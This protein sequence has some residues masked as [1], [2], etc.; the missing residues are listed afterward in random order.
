MLEQLS[1]PSMK[2]WQW[3]FFAAVFAAAFLLRV[4]DLSRIF[5]W[6]DETDLFNESIYG[7]HH[8]SLLDFAFG[9]RNGTTQSWGWSAIFWIVT[10]AFGP[11]I[12]VARMPAVLV[13][14]AGVALLFALVYRLLPESSVNRFWP[15]L[16]AAIFAAISVVQMNYSQQTYPYGATPFLALAVMLARFEVRAAAGVE[17]KATPRL[18]RAVT[19]YTAAISLSFCVHASA[20]LIPALSMAVIGFGALQ[21]LRSQT[22]QERKRLLRW[23]AASGVIIVCA[24]ALGAKNPKYGYRPYLADYYEAPSLHAIPNL[25][26]HAYGLG[27]YAL[28]LFY[29]P[30]LY[31]PNRLNPAILPL[32]LICIL[33]WGL[34]L[35]GQ[36]GREIRHLAVFSAAA[37]ALPASLS[38]LRVFP[39]G[40]VRQLLFLGPFLM[41]FAALGLYSLRANRFAKYMGLA[42]AGACRVH[43]RRA[44]LVAN[45]L[46]CPFRRSW[47]SV[48]QRKILCESR[49]NSWRRKNRFVAVAAQNGRLL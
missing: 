1:P 21:G 9:T 25:L 19:L 8:R 3:V 18:F 47:F 6:L 49:T 4:H 24:A 45:R 17:W 27:S 38:S 35:W 31:F 32:V 12:A 22:G 5:L 44:K 37:I 13:N 23:A 43:R 29:N 15:A 42:A 39:F 26:L 28:N 2:P 40:G 34:A 30:A 14:T 10:R 16:F 33:G 11:S 36:F 20:A 46:A 41:A 48:S 7:N